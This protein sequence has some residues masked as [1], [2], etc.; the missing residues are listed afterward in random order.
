MASIT[1]GPG[2]GSIDRMSRVSKALRE[3]QLAVAE[4]LD[5]AW[6]PIG[7]YRDDDG[8]P[9]GEYESYAWQVLGHLQRGGTTAEIAAL[10]REI[11]ARMMDLGPGPEDTKAAEALV[12]WFRTVVR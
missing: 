2:T 10:L 6:D 3:R 4:L 11:K 1:N 7:V 9:P 12:N 5:S 8:P